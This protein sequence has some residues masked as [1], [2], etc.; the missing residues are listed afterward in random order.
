[1]IR[2]PPRSTRTD[3]PFPYTTLFRSHLLTGGG[4]AGNPLSAKTVK[5]TYL[6]VIRTVYRWGNDN[7][8]VRGN[9]AE[10]VTVLVPRR[11]VVREKGLNDAEAQTILAAT[12]TKPP[13]KL[14]SQRALA[15]R[16]EEHTPE[17]Q[18]LMRISYPV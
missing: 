14:S 7:G 3:T 15:R 1:M 16:S 11:A 18:S 10:R 8:K 2:R 4:A 5:D 9:P 17:L 6:S 13:K 12:L